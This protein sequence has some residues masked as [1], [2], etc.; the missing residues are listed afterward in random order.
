MRRLLGLILAAIFAMALLA[1]TSGQALANH[2]QCGDAITQDTTLD[3]DL[4]G[5]S[6]TALWLGLTD[7]TLD[8]N[9]HTVEGDISTNASG[10][11]NTSQA[12]VAVRNGRVLGELRLVYISRVT[13]TDVTA[14]FVVT[15]GAIAEVARSTLG[16]VSLP[17][18][19]ASIHDNRILNGTGVS[20]SG[21]ATITRN[22]IAGN[23]RGVDSTHGSVTMIENRV[24][25]NTW[26]VFATR[27]GGNT[28]VDNLITG[29]VL[30]G[31]GFAD[32]G[33][34][35]NGNVISAN[36]G[37]GI[38]LRAFSA[39]SG[40]NNTISGNGGAGTRLRQ[41]CLLQLTN[42]TISRNRLDGIVTEDVSAG[43]STV[44]ITDSTLD[45]NGQDGISLFPSTI[46][47]LVGNH[48]WWNGELGID[49]PLGTLGGGNWAKHNGNPLQCAP[50]FLC[51]TKGKPR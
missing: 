7:A 17:R 35:L 41:C 30:D 4:L 13:V 50:G 47:T 43:S 24:Q 15:Y 22:L 3:S 5:C 12:A 38:G 49:A 32:S 18:G 9:R 36:G 37:D 46:A 10:P 26:G 40:T 2:V 33:N 25:G 20:V 29:N 14:N 23:E 48:T 16:G 44:E 21:G 45:R 51:S 6:E 27:G 8:L 11:P 31:M 19:S 42:S 1:L 39:V 34:V 28:F